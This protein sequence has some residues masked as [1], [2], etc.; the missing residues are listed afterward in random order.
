MR[1]E[2]E[3]VIGSQYTCLS[4]FGRGAVYD[5]AAIDTGCIREKELS[6][7]SVGQVIILAAIDVLHKPP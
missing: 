7:I 4:S 2:T 3:R 5:T 6:K 1:Y